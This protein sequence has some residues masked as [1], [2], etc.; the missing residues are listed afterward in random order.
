MVDHQA[1]RSLAG[2]M[3]NAFRLDSAETR[4]HSPQQRMQNAAAL[5]IDRLPRDIF[6]DA[7]PNR[8][9]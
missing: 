7:K 9:D 2:D 1:G 4:Q 3:V 8:H 5:V 6:F